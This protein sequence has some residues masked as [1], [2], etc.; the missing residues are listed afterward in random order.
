V[1]RTLKKSL[2]WDASQASQP[3]RPNLQAFNAM[4]EIIHLQA[5]Q[6]GNQIGSKFWEVI[7]AEHGIDNTGHYSGDADLQLQRVD[8]YFNEVHGGRYVPRAILLDLEPGVL[9]SIRASPV[10][11]LFRPG[12]C[13]KKHEQAQV[14]NFDGL[15]ISDVDM[16]C[17]QTT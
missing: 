2:L 15:W 17:M 14:V 16:Q 13:R 4:R 12:E 1:V 11:Q 6:C 8:V 5:G 3:F 7:S 9:D 10:G